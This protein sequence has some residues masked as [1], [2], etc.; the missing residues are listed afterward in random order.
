MQIKF[1]MPHFINMIMCING[2]LQMFQFCKQEAYPIANNEMK[3][4]KSTK[5][6]FVL[7][8]EQTLIIEIDARK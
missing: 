2:I 1:G 4:A 3:R 8:A 7:Y 6:H 5:T